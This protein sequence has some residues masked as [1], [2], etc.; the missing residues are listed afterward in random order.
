MLATLATPVNAA[1]GRT[2]H[3]PPATDPTTDKSYEAENHEAMDG[4]FGTDDVTRNKVIVR[5]AGI[6]DITGS[7]SKA[8]TQQ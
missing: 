5:N 2:L 1:T 7:Q 8:A 6:E 4:I 3:Q